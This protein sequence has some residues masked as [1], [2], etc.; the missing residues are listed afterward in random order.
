MDQSTQHDVNERLIESEARYQ[1]FIENASDL[2]QSV[3][4]DGTF[5]F[6]NRAWHEKL[7][8]GPEDIPRMTIWDVIHPD[9]LDHCMSFFGL[10]MQGQAFEHIEVTFRTKDGR[11][12]PAEGDATP[13]F[14][15]DEVVA[16][17]SFFRDVTERLRARELEERNAKLELEEQARYLE[18]MAALG[19]LSAGLS[20]ELNNPA[21]AAQRAS[22]LLTE[23]LTKRDVAARAL[24]AGGLTGDDWDGLGAL[25]ETAWQR[26]RAEGPL[27]PLATSEREEAVE[28]WLA[29][30]GVD[31]AWELSSRL[32]G[33]GID[34]AALSSSVASLPAAAL[35]AAAAWIGE[36]I[37]VR[38]LTDVIGRSAKRISELVGAVKSYSHMDRATEQSVDIHDGIEDTLVILGHR[39]KD[40]TIVRDYDRTLPP[41]RALGNS[42][43]QVW[44]NIIDNAVDATDGKGT[45]KIRTRRDGDR[46]VVE[47]AD[48]GSGIAEEDLFCIFEP[49]FTTKRQGQGT[50]LGLNTVWRIVT[51]EHRG[52]ID[53][54]SQPGETVFTVSLPIDGAAG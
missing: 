17:H 3:R 53:V 27:D 47:L 23:S 48:N 22:S 54:A 45:I 20:H 34:A 37:A 9:S 10:V 24:I 35:P 44:T 36:S 29:D 15:G 39:L 7:G 49:F 6:V 1:A 16:T 26:V 19:K 33:A 21:A 13:R 31:R 4:M 2:I 50:G 8:Y 25:L 11:A 43:N 14:V 32:V 12:I 46:A 52:M 42:L 51:E 30:R 18:K 40:V 38:D 41:V 28:E 5:E